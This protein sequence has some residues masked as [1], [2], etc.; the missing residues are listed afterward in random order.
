MKFSLDVK[1]T[2]IC[3]TVL[4]MSSWPLAVQAC[5]ISKAIA[6]LLTPKSSNATESIEK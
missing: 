3:F 1:Y 2:G 5:R 4:F 6:V